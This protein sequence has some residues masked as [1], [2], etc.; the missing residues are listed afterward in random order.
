MLSVINKMYSNKKIIIAIG[1]IILL[2]GLTMSDSSITIE[3]V[4]VA[5]DIAAETSQ[6]A[7]DMMSQFLKQ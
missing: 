7:R 4:K 6:K 2:I 3:D 5:Q 1:F